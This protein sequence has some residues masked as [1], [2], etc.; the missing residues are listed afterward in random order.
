MLGSVEYEDDCSECDGPEKAIES[1][2]T[3]TQEGQWAIP[4]AYGRLTIY[5]P[6]TG[7]QD[8]RQIT[9]GFHWLTSMFERAVVPPYGLQGG[10]PGAL[11][12]VGIERAS[13][14]RQSLPGK[15]NVRLDRGDRV[16]LEIYRDQET[17][18]TAM[19]LLDEVE[20]F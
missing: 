5:S 4:V 16:V 20:R 15:A 7:Q 11:F 13:G 17:Y 3:N 14:E 2:W 19:R 1:T 6:L 10:E 18:V 8:T 12:R 9:L